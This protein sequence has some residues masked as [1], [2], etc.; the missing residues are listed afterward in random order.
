MVL[1]PSSTSR[2]SALRMA[3][4]NGSR[5]PAPQ[6]QQLGI[7]EFLKRNNPLPVSVR[8]APQPKQK[9]SSESQTNT[10]VQ[11]D[12]ILEGVVACLDV[13]YIFF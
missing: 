13:R 2:L 9:T 6:Q 4:N 5:T 7:S 3:R 11:S 12:K 10:I 1:P 8:R